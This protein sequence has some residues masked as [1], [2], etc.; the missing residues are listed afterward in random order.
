MYKDD[1]TH[2]YSAMVGARETFEESFS[3][4]W[5]DAGDSLYV[6]A[7]DGLLLFYRY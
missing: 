4:I 5:N 6:Y 2:I 7:K 3:C 1:A